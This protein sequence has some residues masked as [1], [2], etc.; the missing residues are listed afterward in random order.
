MGITPWLGY[1]MGQYLR[2]MLP[3][4][5]E[6]ETLHKRKNAEIIFSFKRVRPGLVRLGPIGWGQ[7][8]T[9]ISTQRPW[10]CTLL[11]KTQI[12][13][14]REYRK[15]GVEA[16]PNLSNTFTSRGHFYHVVFKAGCRMPG[17]APRTPYSYPQNKWLGGAGHGEEV[18]S[19]GGLETSEVCTAA[20][21][22][23]PQSSLQSRLWGWAAWSG[24]NHLRS[25]SAH[26]LNA[27]SALL[28]SCLWNH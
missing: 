26:R 24:A 10:K 20:G 6:A 17:L 4:Q 2:T 22:D 21:Q 7:L 27:I 14:C 25:P 9:N 8:N 12:W 5:T 1:L 16:S 13:I 3:I 18:T 23:W 15:L 28:A 11:S 19:S